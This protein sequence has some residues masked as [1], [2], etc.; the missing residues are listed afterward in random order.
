MYHQAQIKFQVI[1]I[2]VYIFKN[3]LYSIVFLETFRV[4]RKSQQLLRNISLT[5]ALPTSSLVT[6]GGGKQVFTLK[7]KKTSVVSQFSEPE[8]WFFW[9]HNV[10]LHGPRPFPPLCCAALAGRLH[11][12]IFIGQLSSCPLPQFPSTYEGWVGLTAVLL[13][14]EHKA[15]VH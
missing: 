11:R 15:I 14:C 3:V 2:Y 10:T 5:L 4:F 1:H 7:K 8:R 12:V 9:H 6:D 13:L